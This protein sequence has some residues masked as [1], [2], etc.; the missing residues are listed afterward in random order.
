MMQRWTLESIDWTRFN[1]ARVDATLLA[2]AKTAS[3]VEAN[4]ADYVLYLRNVFADDADFL[5]LIDQWGIEERLHGE[6]LGRWAEM[7]DP[8]FNFKLACHH[9]R[10]GYQF[11]LH[12]DQSVRGSRS[13]ELIARQVVETGTASFY[14]AIRDACEEPLLKDIA[15]RIARDEYFHYALFQQHFRRTQKTV[16]MSLLA[17]LKV[18][19]K[20][21]GEAED[22]ELGYAYFA[23]NI[24]PHDSAAQYAA[25]DYGKDYWRLAMQLY[26]RPHIDNAVRMILRAVGVRSNGWIYRGASA[27]LWWITRRQ[28][29]RVAA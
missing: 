21:F 23:A 26:R 8:S 1:S 24:L 4:A 11:D 28:V 6:A 12:L 25:R 9:F 7:A 13:A 3:L 29:A 10:A 2:V 18:A 14:S 16:P 5:T 19:L 15:G 20:R 22:D 27:A 17:K